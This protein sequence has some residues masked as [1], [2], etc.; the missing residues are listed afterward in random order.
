MIKLDLLKKYLLIAGGTL[1]LAVGVIGIFLPLLPTTPLLLLA[2]Y[3]YI[4]S[5][6]KLYEWLINHPVCGSYI[7]NYMTYRA[8][9][10]RAKIC[11]LVFLWSALFVSMFMVSNLYITILL[12]VIGLGVTIHLKTLKTLSHN[13]DTAC[14][15]K[16]RKS[17]PDPV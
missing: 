8:V 7:Y 14:L 1:S 15:E 5:S 2:A 16:I 3:C 13:D 11:A 4:R 10:R 6:R 17:G 12:T 9:T